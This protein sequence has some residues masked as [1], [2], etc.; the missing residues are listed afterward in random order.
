MRRDFARATA[1]YDEAAALAREVGRRMAERLDYVKLRPSRVADIGC[2]TG[3]GIRELQRRYPNAVPLAVDAVPSMLAAVR[4]R[5]G[6][7]ERWRGRAPRLVNAEVGRLPLAE[8]AFGIVWSNLMLHWVDDPLPVF[9]EL[10]RVAAVDGLLTFSLLGPDT[11]K[12]LRHACEELGLASPLRRYH[13][14]HDIGDMLVASGFADPVMD[15]EMITVTYAG[16]RGLLRDQRRLGVRDRLFGRLAWRDWR[17]VLRH[18]AARRVDDRL[19]ASF[20]VIYGHAWKPQPRATAD[21]RAIVR[22]EPR[23]K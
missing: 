5:S 18:Y 23:K 10:H 6:R 14:M 21:G 20:E 13:D 12:E 1:S 19:A 2:A 17:R 7:L 22:F 9:R 4:A 8:N 3:E 11:L 16:P 15:M